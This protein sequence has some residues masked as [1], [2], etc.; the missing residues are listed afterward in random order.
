MTAMPPTDLQLS[1]L[2]LALMR[3]LWARGE[4]TTAEVHESLGPE[5][6]LA[7]TTVATLLRRLEAR[8]MV[9][10]RREGRQFVYAAAVSE[11]AVRQSMVCGLLDS[12]FSGDRAALV[13][14]LLGQDG[15]S[16]ADLDAIR[17][18]LADPSD[19]EPSGK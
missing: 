13:S 12:L 16:S 6:S 3:V 14:H 15:V 10:H 1:E 19:E 7:Y 9:S 11:S 4:A 5:R 2:Q 18:A 8:G 17:D